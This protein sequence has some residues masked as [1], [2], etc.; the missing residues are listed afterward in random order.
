[1]TEPTTGTIYGLVDPRTGE[2]MYVGQTTKPIEARLA[3]HLAAPAP[4]VRAWIEALAVEGLLPQIAPLHEA[5]V[6][7][8]LDAAERLE[9]KAQAGQRDLLNVVSNEV[10][11]AKRRK[12]SRE[13][14]KRRKAEEDAVTQAW[15]H[16]AWRKVADQIQAATGGPISPARVP[17]HPIPAQL[18]TWYV[19]Y[20]E[21][22]KRL[23]AFLA[24]RYV[25]RQGG[26]V[27]IEGDTPE[28]TQQRE[29]HHRR[30]LLE[31]GLRRYTRAYCATFSSVDERDRWGSGEGIF[32]RGE[33]AYKTKFSS[34][35]RM[36]RY[37]SLIPWAGRALDPWVALAE[38]AGIDTREPDF[39]DWV[40]GEEETRRAVKL[41]QEASTPGYLGVRYQQWDLQIADFALAVGAAHIP[42]FVV[43]ELL[44]RNL[45]GSLTKVAKDRQSTRAMS[46]LLA[47]LN[48]Q[49]LN[50][51]YGRDRLAESDEELGLPG[52]TSA[53]VLGQV[54]GAEQR[55][56]DSEAAR[57]LQRHAGVFDDRDLPDYG[58]WKG[59]HVPAMRTLVACF[60]VVGLFRDA[61]EAARADMVQGVERT[62]SPSEYALR[63]LDELED[64]ITLARAAEAF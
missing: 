33:D 5:V 32:G 42:D 18:W 7:A 63:D 11:N 41:F 60:C 64:G 55:D 37:L 48:P 50:A 21:I 1:M 53:R 49:A 26:G 58:D 40:S 52:G 15:R 12:V 19:E 31:A 29:L 14:A 20:H 39:A 25:L 61:G 46:Q 34:R 2:V 36:A 8:E 4:L 51:V 57:L 30:E 28:A 16:A 47:Q 62:W 45:R 44:A 59:I 17:I 43:P 35:E 38:Q 9:I 56:P 3:G 23:D 10:G 22:K 27:T 13:E 54:F 24:Q 6:L